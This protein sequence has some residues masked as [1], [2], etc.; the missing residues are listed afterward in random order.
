AWLAHSAAKNRQRT[1]KQRCFF[2]IVQ[3]LVMVKSET[4]KSGKF[5]ELTGKE[6]RAVRAE[7]LIN[8]RRRKRRTAGAAAAARPPSPDRCATRRRA[9]DANLRRALWPPTAA[10]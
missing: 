4:S 9:A 5:R 1:L 8:F 7:P 6:R 2:M 10:P 3:L